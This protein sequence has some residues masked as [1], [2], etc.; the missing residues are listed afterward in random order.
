MIKVSPFEIREFLSLND[1]N[2]F[3]EREIVW[4]E[5]FY[6]G[7][8]DKLGSLL[9]EEGLSSDEVEKILRE[10][11]L[12]RGGK[13]GGKGK[14]GRKERAASS[15]EWFDYKGLMFSADKQGKAEMLFE[16]TENAEKVMNRMKEVKMLI[17]DL[18]KT[19]F[20]HGLSF[21]VYLVDGVPERIYVQKA[22]SSGQK[23]R[24]ELFLSTSMT[25]SADE[26]AEEKEEEES[27]RNEEGEMEE[28]SESASEDLTS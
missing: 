13:G 17:E 2:E 4:Y 8:S 18:Q 5:S 16:L 7:Y 21:L 27:D 24:L 14:K 11:G 3:L 10:K 6:K 19:G 1:L 12:A 23:Y 22:E 20:G 26:A 28:A 15:E 9:R 25:Q